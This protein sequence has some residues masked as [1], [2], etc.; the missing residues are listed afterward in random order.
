MKRWASCSQVKPM[1][2][3]DWNESRHT[4]RWQ[5]SLAALAMETATARVGR[6]L[7]DGGDGEVA[8]GTGTLDGEEHVAH[9][10]LDRLEGADGHPELLAVLDVGE[11]HLEERVAGA[12]RLERERDGRLLQRRG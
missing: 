10:V 2:P 3:K 6:V 12:D 9:L 8:E 11:H 5:S 7:V 4:R 1:P